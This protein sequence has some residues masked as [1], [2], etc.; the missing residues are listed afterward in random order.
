MYLPHGRLK[1][2]FPN[3]ARVQQVSFLHVYHHISIVF[4]WWYAL[5][6]YDGGDNYFGS[7]MNSAI[8]VLMYSYYALSLLKINCP[9]KKYL[10]M[11]QLI[12][13][14]TVLGYTFVSEAMVPPDFPL[15]SR[16]SYRVQA[17]EMI[18]LF[19]LFAHF[20][21]KKYSKQRQRRDASKVDGEIPDT[22]TME[23]QDSL[24]SGSSSTDDVAEDNQ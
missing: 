15:L 11:A 1:K 20:Y 7:I 16:M 13:F 8:H 9:W 6:F 12:Q 23:E 14:V 17:F 18:S 2:L 5:R 10:T 24:S 21:N 22:I 19:L 3:P 4:A